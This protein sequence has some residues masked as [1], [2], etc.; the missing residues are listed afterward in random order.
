MGWYT[1]LPTAPD[2]HDA[3]VCAWS[4]RTTGQHLLVPDACVDVL[5]IPGV[6]V[7]ICGPETAAWSFTLPAGTESFGIRF[8]PGQASHALGTS[9]ADL[10]DIRVGFA[11]VLGSAAERTLVDRL[12]H[13]D[14]TTARLT[15]LQNTARCL[16]AGRSDPDPLPAHLT[17]AL[18]TRS[19]SVEELADA[20]SMTGRHLRRRCNDAF[21]YGPSTL[22]AILRLQRFM[23][24]ARSSSGRGL[25]ALASDAGFSDQAHLSRECRRIAS[26]TPTAL[27]A[28]E[29]PDWHGGASVLA[30]RPTDVRSIQD[31]TVRAAEESAA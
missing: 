19:W 9:A 22:R 25:A 31:D 21:G 30:T 20:S 1:P 17:T 3:L 13:A 4:A 16:L 24:L 10:R 14:G 26:L 27:L 8:R 2:L 6:G 5:W 7:R 12:E 18:F 29:A 11:D 23:N 15:V 28:S